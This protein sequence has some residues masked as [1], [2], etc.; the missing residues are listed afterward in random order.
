MLLLYNGMAFGSSFPLTKR[1]LREAIRIPFFVMG[2]NT[3]QQMIE[4][5]ADERKRH[6]EAV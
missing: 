2:P 3:V 1:G 4:G 6:S 5:T